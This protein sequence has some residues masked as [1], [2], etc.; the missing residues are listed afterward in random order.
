M[1]IQTTGF[2]KG[3]SDP[4]W[5]GQVDIG[6]KID[7]FAPVRENHPPPGVMPDELLPEGVKKP[8]LFT[9]VSM[10]K[11]S[12][13]LTVKN[14]VI[15]SPM[16][17]YSARDGLPSP[18]HLAHLG[19]FALHGVGTIMVEASGVVPEGRI[20]PQCLGIWNEEQKRAHASLVS[21]LKS[22]TDGLTVGIQLAH[23]GRKASAWSPFYR[24]ERS[25]KVW[26]TREEGGW[27][28]TVVAPSAIA[29]GEGWITPKE[30]DLEGIKR[31]EEAFVDSAR[32]AFEAGY[33]F[34]EL[35][36]AH[37]Y[38]FHSFLSPL[39]NHRTDE[40]GGNLENRARILTDC[41]KRIR[42][43]HPDKSVWVRVSTTDFAE[44][45]GSP[46]WKIQ[47]SV[48]LAKLLDQAGIDLLDCSAGGL[49]PFQKIQP[50]PGYQL[51]GARAVSKLGLAKLLVGAVGMMEGPEGEPGTLAERSIQ[52]GDCDVVL[53]ARGI[54]ANPKWVEEVA[55]HLTGTRCS[56]NPQYHRVHPA[57]RKEL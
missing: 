48:Q 17:Q 24:G 10:P 47:D 55:I 56:G 13:G 33:D 53:L 14:R 26:V 23:A 25:N 3:Q 54:M 38:L 12:G 15:V 41:V 30:L 35:H 32:R 2:N 20:T 5:D 36:A 46:S 22:F 7:S 4:V 16:C 40:Y 42:S 8:K 28:D 49:V 34:V 9:S 44:D 45:C 29:Y 37:G 1:T 27:P 51:P 11:S 21:G 39:S 43:N 57:K 6:L 19:S 31:I 18:Y 52:E 50:G